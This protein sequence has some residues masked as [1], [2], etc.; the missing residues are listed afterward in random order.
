[1]PLAGAVVCALTVLAVSLP[2]LVR[3]RQGAVAQYYG[4]GAV[5]PTAL[6]FVGLIT[7]VAFAAGAYERSTPELVAG[8]VLVAGVGSL[9]VVLQWLVALGS[10]TVDV[11]PAGAVSLRWHPVSILVASALWAALATWYARVLGLL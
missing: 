5:S 9:L 3:T 1:M 10:L 11:T 8:I 4:E 7:V 6:A 2:Y